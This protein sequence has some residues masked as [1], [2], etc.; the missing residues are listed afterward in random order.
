[1]KAL[2][3]AAPVERTTGVLVDDQHVA[4]HDDIVLVALEQ[5]LGLDGVVEVGDQRRVLGLVQVVDAEA[6]LDDRDALLD[7]RDRALLLVHLVVL[8]ALQSTNEPRELRV[9]LHRVLGGAGDDERGARLVHEDRVD[10]V[11]DRVVV[12]ALHAVVE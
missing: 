5:L 6:V 4:V 11:D 9:P 12:T 1:M 7:D 10:L 8:V 3:V 2:V